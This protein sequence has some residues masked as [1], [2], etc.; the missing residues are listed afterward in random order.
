MAC[1]LLL[2][3]RQ[4][5]PARRSI[6]LGGSRLLLS[7]RKTPPGSSGG[8]DGDDK[9]GGEAPRAPD[10]P[11]RI[12]RRSSGGIPERFL[13]A[14]LRKPEGLLRAT[15]VKP[16]D[17]VWITPEVL[18]SFE[19][20][21]L[22]KDLQL[23]EDSDYEYLANRRRQ[24]SAVEPEEYDYT[25]HAA[26]R[27]KPHELFARLDKGDSSRP[28]CDKKRRFHIVPQDKITVANLPLLR[29][30][31]SENG[32][33]LKRSLTRLCSRCQRRIRNTIKRARNLGFIPHDAGYDPVNLVGFPDDD[34]KARISRTI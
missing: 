14:K 13:D 5:A 19:R 6:L 4:R 9:S 30:F 8:E 26:A 28:R 16:D 22:L 20:N 1:R 12:A 27:E 11:P 18:N 29:E 17:D 34:H 31:L 21:Y 32:T 2:V 7:S 25:T 15:A 23:S 24:G 33:I 3:A 10:D